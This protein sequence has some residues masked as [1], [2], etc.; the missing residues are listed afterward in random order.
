MD[1]EGAAVALEKDTQ[2]PISTTDK[3]SEQKK[4]FKPGD[5]VYHASNPNLLWVVTVLL[6]EHIRCEHVYDDGTVLHRDFPVE[7]LRLNKPGDGKL[8]AVS[9]FSA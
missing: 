3:M 1:V 9:G 5:V 7:S 4:E 2:E 8:P 6:S